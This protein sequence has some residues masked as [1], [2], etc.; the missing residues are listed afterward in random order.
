MCGIAG[1]LTPE[2]ESRGGNG[3]AIVERMTSALRHRGPDGSGFHCSG[4]AFLGH[5]RL[6]IVDVAHGQQPLYTEDRSKVIIYNGEVFNHA[7]VRA[8]LQGLGQ[9]FQTNCDTET[10]LLAS[11]R[12][13]IEGV[14]RFRGM[15]AFCIW[16]EQRRRLFAVRDRLGIKPFYYFWDGRT[17]A[18]ASEIKALLEHPAVSAEPNDAVMN[19]Y[20]AF[21]YVSSE[22]T[23]FKGIR[24]LMPGHWLE[25]FE[26][27]QGKPQLKIERY[28]DVPPAEKVEHSDEEWVAETLRRLDETVQ[29]R[30]MADVPL[31]AFLSGGVD[32]SAITALIQRHAAGRVKTFSVGYREEQYSELT[33]ARRVAEQLGTDHHEVVMG[34]EDFFGALPG[35]VY[36]EDEPIAWPSS[37]SL[38]FVSKLAVRDVKVV[39]TGEGSDELFGGYVRYRRN[40]QNMA[41]ASIY[42]Y[43]PAPLRN[44]IKGAAL[45]FP[46]IGRDRRR[47]IGHT[48]IGRDL[49]LESL[50][51]DNFYTAFSA[52]ERERLAR[53]P[54]GNAYATYLSYWD[55]RPQDSLLGRMLYADQKTYLVELLMKQDQMSMA[56]S[57]ESRVPFLD[58]E[59]VA[60]AAT[61]PDRLKIHNG[62]QKYIL[63][64]AVESLLPRDIIYREKMGFPTPL[65]QWLRD[66]DMKPMLTKLAARDSFIS[67]W[68]HP[69]AVQQLV[70]G[71]LDASIDGTDRIWRLLNLETWGGI[72]FG[73]N[74]LRERA[75]ESLHAAAAV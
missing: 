28:W 2:F 52:A 26:D 15:F 75:A 30:L 7:S 5:R 24:K 71:H 22:Q 48:F 57:I 18:F 25:W 53:S 16:D 70:G 37:I 59:F 41:A 14:K 3:R 4:P 10:M 55:K 64:K 49:T 31:G 29:L 36:H 45:N 39:L 56:T 68:V 13:G 58:H 32:S 34:K 23:M 67:R 6:A 8:E 17:F 73:K 12:W 65:R 40:Q 43:V 19:E 20:L 1:F 47:Q 42:G 11:A 21:G 63:K 54:A 27:S 60:Y 62:E 38:Y 44:A 74:A 72:F 9:R 61:V 69:E 51:L 46:L 33:Y 66:P 35:L 50:Y